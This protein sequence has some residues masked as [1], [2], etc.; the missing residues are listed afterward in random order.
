M[1]PKCE[2]FGTSPHQL[3][4]ILG[5]TGRARIPWRMAREG[6]DPFAASALVEGAR[7]RLLAACETT[8][9]QLQD[10]RVAAC[11]TVKLRLDLRDGA[12]IET[13]VV[14]SAGRTTVCLSSQ[15]GCARGCTFCVTATM[16]LIRSLSAAEIVAQ[17]YL[18]VR[19]A[20]DAGMPPLRNVVYMGMGEPLD[21][22]EAVQRSLQVL[23]DPHA[24]GLGPAR[25]TLSTIGPSPEAIRAARH[26]PGRLAWSLHSAREETRRLLIP[27][28]A[29]RARLVDLRQAFVE[30]VAERGEDLFVEITLIAG[31]ND[32]VDDA[33]QMV[34]FLAPLQP[35]VRVN[36]LSLNSGRAGVS[37]SSDA[38]AERY[39]Q[40]MRDAGYLCIIRRARGTDAGAA[41]G[42]LAVES[43]A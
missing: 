29:A 24:F 4:E 32:D 43:S 5:G 16:G 10:R 12:V 2:F 37:P 14:P 38:A 41:C 20:R 30:V 23:T 1:G 33:R 19:E 39:R 27:N 13:V 7:R 36:L 25:I 26:L 11:G 8:P 22:L 31:V 17:V 18:A 40:A 3:A 34:D 15:V 28:T 9:L 35:A 21:N 42:Q 6:R